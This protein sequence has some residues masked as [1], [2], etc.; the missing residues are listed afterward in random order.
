[1]SVRF[2]WVGFIVQIFCIFAN[3]LT[4]FISSQE[5]DIEVT[6]YYLGLIY[7]FQIC[8]F[9][10]LIFEALFGAHMLRIVMSFWWIYPF[11][12]VYYGHLLF[13]QLVKER[14]QLY[15]YRDGLTHNIWHWADAVDSSLLVTYTQSLREENTSCHAETEQSGA[16]RERALYLNEHRMTISSL[17]RLWLMCLNKL[18]GW[19]R[20]KVKPV[21]LRDRWGAGGPTEKRAIKMGILSHRMRPYLAGLLTARPLG[22]C[23]AQGC[24]G[25]PWNFSCYS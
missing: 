12:V 22:P 25:S 1:M 2:C 13:M 21:R 3:F 10:L 23:E 16:L 4:N 9:L 11:V 8:Q 14:F 19:Q 17:D 20:G 5:E 24:Q 15:R 7:P 6:M 18:M